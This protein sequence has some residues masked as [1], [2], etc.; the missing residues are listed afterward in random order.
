[1]MTRVMMMMMMKY[2]FSND[3]VDFVVAVFVFLPT[4][5]VFQSI[6]AFSFHL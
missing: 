1:M 4:F 2:H 3:F 5:A 6:S